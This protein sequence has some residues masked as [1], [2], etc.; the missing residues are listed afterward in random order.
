[1]KWEI[2][3]SALA[4]FRLG[5]LDRYTLWLIFSWIA[6]NLENCQDPRSIGEPIVKGRQDRWRYKIGKY[7][8]LC[9][10]RDKDILIV[11]I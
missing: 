5:E 1:M 9:E 10:I 7:R 11:T 8:L 4:Q 3:F 6:K 2:R